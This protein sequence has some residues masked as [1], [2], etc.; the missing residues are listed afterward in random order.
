MIA[1]RVLGLAACVC[2]AACANQPRAMFVARAPVR[3]SLVLG[4]G[5][6]DASRFAARSDARL[7][8]IGDAERRVA[9]EAVISVYDRQQIFDGRLYNDYRSV[10]RTYERLAR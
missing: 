3:S 8:A 2:L 7:G 1:V 4:A 9:E 6:A 5:G 10:T